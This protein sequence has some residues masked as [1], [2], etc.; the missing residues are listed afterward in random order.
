[1]TFKHKLSKRLAMMRDA[2]AVLAL[3]A[4]FAC[5]GDQ[6]ISAPSQSDG[7]H[8]RPSITS[9]TVVPTNPTIL[10]AESFEDD[11]FATRGW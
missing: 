9:V 10:F 1:M 11:A 4:P 3:L 5:A 7:G 2:A 8:A 6:P